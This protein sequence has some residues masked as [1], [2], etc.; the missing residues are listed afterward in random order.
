[1]HTT[2]PLSTV[3]PGPWPE[4]IVRALHHPFEYVRVGEELVCTYLETPPPFNPSALQ[5]WVADAAK[6]VDSP[7]P[8]TALEVLEDCVRYAQMMRLA[9]WQVYLRTRH[10]N[11]WDH[12]ACAAPQHMPELLTM[13]EAPED[14]PGC[15]TPTNPEGD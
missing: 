9:Q 6:I 12:C 5:Q 13:P 8:D 3:P 14:C 2:L 4:V 11:T 10:V 1:M 15:A 7:A